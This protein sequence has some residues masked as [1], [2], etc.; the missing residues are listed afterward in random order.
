MSQSQAL[1][2]TEKQASTRD[3]TGADGTVDATAIAHAWI[4]ISATDT[5]I[6]KVQ[7]VVAGRP[8]PVSHIL[9]ASMLSPCLEKQD[10]VFCIGLAPA[11][12]AMAAH[13]QAEDIITTYLGKT[14]PTGAEAVTVDDVVANFATPAPTIAIIALHMSQGQDW[15]DVRQIAAAAVKSETPALILVSTD[16]PLPQGAVVDEVF[17]TDATTCTSMAVTLQTA[18]QQVRTQG[19]I[20]VIGIQN[21]SCA[22]NDHVVMTMANMAPAVW[23]AAM[24]A[25]EDAAERAET[26]AYWAP[27]S[28]Y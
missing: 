9:M 2:M 12:W 4:N 13:A 27:V 22:L 5:V 20:R 28:T 10:R 11:V 8:S 1:R 15:S 7:G 18:L 19:A 14:W 21:E 23:D 17:A 24:A 16:M 25:A 6:S 26:R 3:I